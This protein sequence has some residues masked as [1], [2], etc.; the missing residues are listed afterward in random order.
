MR[1]ILMFLHQAIYLLASLA[2][3]LFNVHVLDLA[4]PL[5]ALGNGLDNHLLGCIF[6]LLLHTRHIFMFLYHYIYTP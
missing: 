6:F 1:N 4:F 3:I 5:G 2:S